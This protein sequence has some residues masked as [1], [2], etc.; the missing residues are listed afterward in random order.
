VLFFSH[1]P[2]Q[3]A[4]EIATLERSNVV[5]HYQNNAFYPGMP[6]VSGGKGAT[7]IFPMAE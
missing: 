2:H 4:K 6:H 7:N 5:C 1:I 3:G